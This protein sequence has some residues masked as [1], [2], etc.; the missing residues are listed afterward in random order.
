VKRGGANQSKAGEADA[1]GQG[2]WH[3]GEES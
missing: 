1:V 2:G 3:T